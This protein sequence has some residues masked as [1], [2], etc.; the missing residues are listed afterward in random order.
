MF[1]FDPAAPLADELAPALASL[2]PLRAANNL[3]LLG[4]AMGPDRAAS[5]AF[6]ARHGLSF[7]V[8]DDSSGTLTRRM[9]LRDGAAV[10]AADA[11]GLVVLARRH[12]GPSEPADAKWL[13]VDLADALRLRSGEA[14]RGDRPWERP[15][16]PDFERPL[17]HDASTL[18]LSA[19]RGRAV[20]LVFFLHHCPYCQAALRTLQAEL[21]GID[22]K[23]RPLLLGVEISGRE[24]E[25]IQ[26]ALAAAGIGPFPMIHDL[27]RALRD[28][29][30]VFGEVPVAV[31][32]DPA[33]R[34]VFRTKPGWDA[35]RDPDIVAA[36]LAR[37]AGAPVP[38]RLAASGYSGNELCGACHELEYATGSMTSHA[39]AFDTLVTR[40]AER[41]VE[42]VGC[43]V[44]GFGE[45]GG[46]TLEPTPSGERSDFE[47]VGC[48]ACHGRG[49][50][51][52]SRDVVGDADYVPVCLGCHDQQHSLGFDYERFRPRISHAALAALVPEEREARAAAATPHSA[53]LQ[54]GEFVGSDP[55][56]ACHAAEHATWSAGAHARAFT[57]LERAGKGD[58]AAC[59]RC[60]TT[61][62]GRAG[63][64]SETVPAASRPDL[65]RVGCE[66]C[67]G[68][69]SAHVADG[70]RRRGD[71][72]ALRDK[73]E[74]CVILQICGDC[75]DDANDPGFAFA[76]HEKIERQRHG[77][78]G[79]T[80]A[81]P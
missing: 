34:I 8:L 53:P 30:G 64:L 9:R 55:C 41:R 2:V 61:G 6:A 37:S 52:R 67:H 39:S 43:P 60:H 54:A 42:C 11:S 1:F 47:N 46:Y 69:G 50:P 44:V 66:S 78:L 73:C 19:L 13:A 35:Q 28:A 17:L 3:E 76:V 40:G 14:R 36:W 63:G 72:L 15:L 27:D 29:Y 21:P 4:V 79:A 18:R 58:D 22:E 62:F 24:D 68:P 71:I 48:E 65:A 38:M 56:R 20:V 5:A 70:A 81:D 51:H 7:P 49:G 12:F 32:I 10:I 23:V 33:G 25:V 80:K 16:A 75:H 26:S 59:L 77:T 31:M 74:S 57:S 45:R